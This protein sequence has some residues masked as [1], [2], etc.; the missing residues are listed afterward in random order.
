MRGIMRKIS[1]IM[2]ILSL[3]TIFSIGCTKKEE[4]SGNKEYKYYT[5]EQVKDSIE[6]KED[7]ILLDIQVKEEWDKHHIKGAIE[8]NAYPVKTDEQKKKLDNSLPSISE[9]ENP[10]VIICPGGKGGATRTYD[11]LMKKGIKEDRLYILEN[12]QSKWPYDE[13][14]EK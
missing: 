7:I 12:G 8:T 4:T 13:L 9:N 5:A 2:V 6:K 10:I 11:Y 3:F 1:I 14:L